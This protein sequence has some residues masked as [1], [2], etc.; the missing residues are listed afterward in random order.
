[1]SPSGHIA[2]WSPRLTASHAI[3]FT[4]LAGPLLLCSPRVEE[5]AKI[6]A[7]DQHRSPVVAGRESALHPVPHGV[8]VN[9]KQARDLFHAVVP[10]DLGKARVRVALTHGAARPRC[11]FA[12]AGAGIGVSVFRGAPTLF[13]P[14]GLET[15]ETGETDSTCQA[16][17][18]RLPLARTKR[19]PPTMRPACRLIRGL[20]RQAQGRGGSDLAAPVRLNV[21]SGSARLRIQL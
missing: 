17:A 2:G 13:A 6:A 1:M 20:S 21:Q 7:E 10:V 4:R 16:S 8:P 19:R 11:S 3:D 18:E 14:G 5:G 9:P 12:T 15:D